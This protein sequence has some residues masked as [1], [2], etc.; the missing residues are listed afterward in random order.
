MTYIR[1]FSEITI[2]DVPTVGGKNASLGEM[3][4][5]LRPLGVKIPN[6]FAVTADAYWYLV[7]SGGV[8]DEM[9]RTLDRLHKED[10]DDLAFRGHRLRELIY[11][12][13]LPA[14]LA[15]EIRDA[16]RRLCIEYGENCDVAVRSSA[17]AE[18]LPTASFA[19]QQETYLNIRGEAQL[20]DACRRCFASLFTDRAISY[21]IDQG[22]DHFKV[23]LSIGIM[24]MVRSDRA[25]SGVIF[26][27]DTETG[28]RDTVLVTGAW[29]LGENVVQGAV[30]PDEF[31]VFKPTLRRGFRPIVRRKLGEKKIKMI[32][33]TGTSKHLTRNVEV[34]KEERRRYCLADAEVLELA[35]QALLI[36]EH[37]SKRAGHD[38]PM[39]IEWAKDGV[40]GE[41]FIVQAR[42]ETVESQKRLDFLETYI[43]ERK[44]EVLVTGTS[45]GG[46]IAAG[47]AR[48]ITDVHKLHEFNPGEVL[49]ADTTT[50]DWE[51][52]MKTAAAIV[53]NKGG[54]TCHAAIVS[55]ELGIPSVVGTGDGTGRVATGRE[56]TVSCA[57]GDVGRIYD[58][59]L[60]FRVE[61]A[62][63]SGMRRPR[64]KIMMNLGNP[65]EAFSLC[66]IPNDGVGL[67]RME[68]IITNHIKV[69][70][71]A[72][73]HPERVEDEAARRE[74][75]RLTA[76]YPDPPAYFVE[77]L[78]E[79]IGA[80]AAAFHPK[81]V[82][83]RMSDFKTNEYASLLGGRA[84]EPDEENPMIGFRGASRYYDER[85]R[86]GFALECRALKRVRDEMGLANV[87]PMIPF[88][89]R[90]VEAK[91]VLAEMAANGLVRGENS[92]EVYVMCEIPNNVIMIDEFSQLFDGFSIGS[93]DLTQLTLGIDRDSA[94]VAHV[95]DERD[96]GVMRLIASVVEGARR[97]HR[98]SGI[99][100][101][102]PSD[103]PEF[104]AFLV[105]EGIDSISLN[106]D[107][108]LKIT[109]RVLEMEQELEKP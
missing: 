81:P 42:P 29:G 65:E 39:D 66:R 27:L 96:P 80:I 15:A 77:K 63:L 88:C 13:P 84:F 93:N 33:G 75:G 102:A 14:D 70:P 7:R 1:W 46:K 62:D 11:G 83:V 104:A 85:Y 92:L 86:E 32:Y 20:L 43:L 26:T 72:L 38:V 79:G 71:M 89:R 55:R 61:R 22:F 107:S 103:Y 2:D 91:K 82:I 59:A 95:F 51:P 35:R 56:I 23:G 98:H 106:P 44:G 108:I 90:I 100:G 36:E 28:F 68:F 74:I 99:C 50:P 16:Y 47:P 57:E 60:P 58:G 37:Y 97:N 5:E 54:R 64:T 52:V 18:D 53:T 4:R 17:T 34:P 3:Y 69:H 109:L 101:Q 9:R 19:G 12:A 105:R 25:S 73:V 31:T 41:I 87:I 21:R 49:V 30:N 48:I 8:L 78:A 76:G 45:V 67:A 24:K 94:L 6:G 40:S 10:V